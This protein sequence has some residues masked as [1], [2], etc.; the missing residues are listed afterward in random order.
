[1][2]QSLIWCRTLLHSSVIE[3]S[4]ISISSQ[5]VQLQHRIT[6]FARI[7]GWYFICTSI[8]HILEI[9]NVEYSENDTN[10]IKALL[11]FS[12]HKCTILF[13]NAYIA[14]H[15]IEVVQKGY[16]IHMLSCVCKGSWRRKIFFQVTMQ[17]S[18][19]RRCLP[20][21]WMS[22]IFFSDP[23]PIIVYPWK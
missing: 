17:R 1:M 11:S 8:T 22:P 10:E 21:Q 16:K 2:G 15:R 19:G 4:Q 18:P 5:F 23:S 20:Q 7:T 9:M 13:Y 14:S 3:S 6:L 12:W